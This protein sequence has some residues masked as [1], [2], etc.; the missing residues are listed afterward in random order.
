MTDLINRI[1]APKG[2]WNLVIQLLLLKN[3]LERSRLVRVGEDIIFWARLMLKK[4]NGWACRTKNLFYIS[5]NT[6]V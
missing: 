5:K 3:S 6:S 4:I 2:T 1:F